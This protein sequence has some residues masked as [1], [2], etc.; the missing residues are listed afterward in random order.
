MFTI[1]KEKEITRANNGSKCKSYFSHFD[2]HFG[3]LPYF[4]SPQFFIKLPSLFFLFLPL[5]KFISLLNVDFISGDNLFINCSLQ[6]KKK[7]LV[8]RTLN[9]NTT[10][11]Y[12]YIYI[13]VL[14][15]LLPGVICHC[16]LPRLLWLF[17]LCL[18]LLFH[19]LPCFASVP[20]LI[21]LII[22]KKLNYNGD[23]KINLFWK[24]F[25]SFKVSKVDTLFPYK[26]LN[27][28]QANQILFQTIKMHQN[29]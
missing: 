24:L 13:F 8:I 6:S 5:P 19:A 9:T 21:K 26:C 22:P 28:F 17:T 16:Y 1:Y 15:T 7:V 18:W 11:I 2:F 4:F 14:A 3:F 20:P 29:I 25:C 10:F 27:R 23:N 12:I